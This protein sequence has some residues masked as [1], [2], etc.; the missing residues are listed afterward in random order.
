M[1]KLQHSQQTRIVSKSYLDDQQKTVFRLNGLPVRRHDVAEEF[2]MTSIRAFTNLQR[3]CEKYDIRSVTQLWRVGL[4]G[5]L[6]IRGVGEVICLAA[7][8]VIARVHGLPVEAWIEHHIS[9]KGAI[10]AARKK[11]AKRRRRERRAEKIVTFVPKSA[12]R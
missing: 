6:D 12:I 11:V 8:H 3:V 4:Q 9:M 5:L 2:G 7:G 1:P 10:G